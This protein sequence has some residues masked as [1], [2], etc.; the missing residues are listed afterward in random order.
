MKGIF[1]L[2]LVGIASADNTPVLKHVVHVSSSGLHAPDTIYPWTKN[3]SDNFQTPGAL[4]SVG[5]RQNYYIGNEMRERMVK[6]QSLLDESFN[7]HQYY[8]QSKFAARNSNSLESFMHG[9]YPPASNDLTI[10]ESQ[11]A[12]ALPP[13]PSSS[14]SDFITSL[15]NAA[16]PH[17]FTPFPIQM[18]APEDDLML[19]MNQQNCKQYDDLIANY[20]HTG[21]Y[22]QDVEKLAPQIEKIGKAAGHKHLEYDEAVKM[23]QYHKAAT[24]VGMDLTVH[25]DSDDCDAIL[26]NEQYYR[27]SFQS[28]QYQLGSVDF[29]NKLFKQLNGLSNDN[30]EDMPVYSHYN[31]DTENLNM[32]MLAY[33]YCDGHWPLQPEASQLIFEF[34]QKGDDYVVSGSYN[35]LP[36]EWYPGFLKDVT[37][38]DF[39]TTISQNHFREGMDAAADQCKK[40]I[41]TA[42]TE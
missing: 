41:F 7:A 35:D 24:R 29:Y 17:G 21:F 19:G 12:R 30:S 32:I 14:A 33:G 18:V 39:M 5:E 27:I 36:M 1:A 6:E 26:F 37:I 9:I 23:C 20:H 34:Y 2:S 4:T 25:L 13:N 10:D 28:A 16:L 42:T 11:E 31:T 3:P 22:Q 38:E 40:G 15:G 8:I